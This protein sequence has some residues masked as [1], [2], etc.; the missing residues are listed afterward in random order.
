MLRDWCQ[1]CSDQNVAV[2]QKYEQAQCG[3]NTP[4]QQVWFLAA[5]PYIRPRLFARAGHR[6]ERARAAYTG[7]ICGAF[8][9]QQ[10]DTCSCCC[11]VWDNVLRVRAHTHLQCSNPSLHQATHF[12][13]MISSK[14]PTLNGDPRRSSTCTRGVAVR[15]RP[16]GSLRGLQT[17]QQCQLSCIHGSACSACIIRPVSFRT[18]ADPCVW[19]C[20]AISSSVPWMLFGACAHPRFGPRA[21]CADERRALRSGPECMRVQHHTAQTQGHVPGNRCGAL[22]PAQVS[23]WSGDPWSTLPRVVPALVEPTVGWSI[24][25]LSSQVPLP[26]GF[27]PFS[28][29]IHIYMRD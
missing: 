10:A 4:D 2:R 13:S 18:C 12:S 24:L 14:V 1:F 15:H 28:P 25:K 19:P 27:L 8:G 22:Q 21:T 23:E 16:G 26:A 5:A 11:T 9:R 29:A 20:P 3:A 6:R 7:L 17:C